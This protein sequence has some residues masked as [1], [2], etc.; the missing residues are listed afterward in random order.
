MSPKAAT[1]TSQETP[2]AA[3]AL[4]V[5]LQ[6]GP[7]RSLGRVAEQI[8]HKHDRHVKRWSARYGWAKKAAEHDAKQREVYAKKAETKLE[9]LA[10]RH[11]Q[12]ARAGLALAART[13]QA[14]AAKP[15]PLS[16]SEAI[17]M[18]EACAKLERLALGEATDRHDVQAK[19]TQ[20]EPPAPYHELMRDPA[21]RRLFEAVLNAESQ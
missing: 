19:V 12:I 11:V 8:G 2:K 13:I 15:Q 21:T 18:I 4:Q 14:L 7:S 9:E 17:R 1:K 6:Q 5:Y 3:H 10:E 16:P 20:V